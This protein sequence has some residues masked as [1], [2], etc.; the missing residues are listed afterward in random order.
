MSFIAVIVVHNSVISI[1]SQNN[2]YCLRLAS[3]EQ[4][5]LWITVMSN[6]SCT[7]LSGEDF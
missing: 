2:V 3:E 6:C 1:I 5:K 4:L 7:E